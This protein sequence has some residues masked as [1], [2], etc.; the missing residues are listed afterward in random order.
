M[1][2]KL[3]RVPVDA[4]PP[5]VEHESLTSRVFIEIGRADREGGV[6]TADREEPNVDWDSVRPC[7]REVEINL[8]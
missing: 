6:V 7:N 4:E 2:R 1:G 5:E 8:R 3:E